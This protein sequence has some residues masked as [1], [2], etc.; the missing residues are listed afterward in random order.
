ML[1]MDKGNVTCTHLY[2]PVHTHTYNETLFNHKEEVMK[3]AG[4]LMKLDSI[5][6]SDIS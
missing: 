5:T 1:M 3:F 6:F 4:K 2:T